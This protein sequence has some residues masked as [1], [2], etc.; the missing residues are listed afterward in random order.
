MRDASA[1]MAAI[2]V[3]RRSPRRLARD[4]RGA[5][6]VEFAM[7]VAPLMA[8]LVAI[9]ETSLTFFAQ[10]TLD[11][12]AEKSVRQLMTGTAQASGMSAA[13]FKTAVCTNLPAFMKC[14]RVMVDVQQVGTSFAAADPTAP[15][16]TFDSSGNPNNSFKFSPGGP[17]QITVVK[18]MYIWPVVGGPLGFNI[19]TL[20]NGARLLM[21]TSVFKTEP[22]A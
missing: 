18:I 20:S 12:T 10:Q 6:I 7:V 22:Y 17:G 16:I 5:T 9:L 15:T 2:R 14:S 1:G 19:A 4:T 8:L 3:L 21:A 11:T 13:Q